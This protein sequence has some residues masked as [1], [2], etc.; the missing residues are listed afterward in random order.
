MAEMF[1][2]IDVL[3]QIEIVNSWTFFDDDIKCGLSTVV[4]PKPSKV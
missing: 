2:K 4:C 3:I 1:L